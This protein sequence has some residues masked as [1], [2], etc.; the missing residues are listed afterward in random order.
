MKKKRRAGFTLI[1]VI[2]AGALAAI[3]MVML[4]PP[5]VQG[6]TMAM[7]ERSRLKMFQDGDMLMNNLNSVLQ[8][9]VLPVVTDPSAV[10]NNTP[11]TISGTPTFRELINS[12]QGF[13]TNGR[14]WRTQL[15][16]GTD[17]IPFCIPVF[18]ENTGSRLDSN[19][20]PV[21]GID[22][23]DGT[24]MVAANY[25]IANAG[26]EFYL[27]SNIHPELAA[28]NPAAFGVSSG[29]AIDVA[30]DARFAQPLAFP[31]GS[32]AAYAVIRFLPTMGE[33][34]APVILR[35]TD[36]RFDLNEDGNIADTFA[37][38]SI[39]LV[40]ASGDGNGIITQSL[41]PVGVLMQLNTDAAS[42]TPLFQLVGGFGANNSPSGLQWNG[43]SSASNDSYTLLVRML[44]F[45]RYGQ[46]SVLGFNTGGKP[47]LAYKFQSFITLRN[48]A[49]NWN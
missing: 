49:L 45:D 11:A 46:T 26:K 34:G 36:L 33:D 29:G 48:Q 16:A 6:L 20:V 38:G 10:A 9:A 5:M 19:M 28:L 12:T 8:A 31:G 2:V 47:Y 24:H 27:N 17:F 14:D 30:S 4:F 39:Q 18:F 44:L 23:P 41:S 35:E 21:L 1:E 3:F 13:W 32:N 7:R 22:L 42:Y 37:L 25:T 40:Y 43:A 15:L